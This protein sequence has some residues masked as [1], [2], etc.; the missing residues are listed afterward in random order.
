MK[1]IRTIPANIN[2]IIIENASELDQLITPDLF[3]VTSHEPINGITEFFLAVIPL[4]SGAYD[5][6]QIQMAVVDGA[7]INLCRSCVQE[8]FGVWSSTAVSSDTRPN[9]LP[10]FTMFDSNLNKPIWL[11]SIAPDVAEVCTLEITLGEVMDAGTITIT[12]DGVDAT[13]E[14]LAEDTAPQIATK[15]Q[16]TEI[17]G[18]DST[19]EDNI[20]TFTKTTPGANSAPEFADTDTTGA[21]GEFTVTTPGTCNVWVDATGTEV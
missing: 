17:A 20:V 3:A 9:R 16:G 15:I 6:M 2:G 10:G 11:K 1:L 19:V 5:I 21:I 4:G 7:L 18:W 12:L 13:V 8:T 14:I